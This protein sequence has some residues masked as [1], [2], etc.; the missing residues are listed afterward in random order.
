MDILSLFEWPYT[1]DIQ[2]KI[3]RGVSLGRSMINHSQVAIICRWGMS[4]WRETLVCNYHTLHSVCVHTFKYSARGATNWRVLERRERRVRPR[5][6]SWHP[7]CW[8]WCGE[9]MHWRI[10]LCVCD[11]GGTRT[12][13]GTHSGGHGSET[14]ACLKRAGGSMS[15]DA[16]GC[17]S[18]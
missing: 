15:L 10:S 17:H 11:H 1:V 14:C 18:T 8:C 4:L 12:P 16:W 7:C 2:S 13:G 9:R 3:E 5:G 6:G